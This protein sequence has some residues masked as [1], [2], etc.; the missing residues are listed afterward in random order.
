M[1]SGF[2][3]RLMV[4]LGLDD[5]ELDRGLNNQAK[6]AKRFGATFQTALG[7]AAGMAGAAAATAFGGGILNAGKSLLMANASAEQYRNSLETVTG[8]QKR[9]NEM[10]ANLQKFAKDTPFEFPELVQSAINLEAFGINTDKWLTTIGDTA[11]A[12][13]KSVDQVTQAIMDA[14]TGEYERLKELGIK[15]SVDGDK[16]VLAYRGR[17]VEVDKTNREMVLS[18]IQ[19][20]WNSGYAGAMKKQSRTFIGQWST[21]K[22]NINQLM[23]RASMGVFKFAKNGLAGVN[24]F[25]SAF[26]NAQE[27]GLGT[28]DALWQALRSTVLKVFGRETFAEVRGTLDSIR[29]NVERVG[30]V[31]RKVGAA[32]WGAFGGVFTFIGKHAKTIATLAAG[33]LSVWAAVSAGGLVLG[34]I[35]GL[36]AAFASPF[37]LLIGVAALFASAYI[38]NW[39]GVRDITNKVVKKVLPVIGRLIA[40]FMGGKGLHAAIADLP[41]PV[42]KVAIMFARLSGMV[43]NF[44]SA[45]QRNGPVAAF[46]QFSHDLEKLGRT[47]GNFVAMA[48]LGRSAA[49]IKDGFRLIG[50]II[51]QT[52]ALVDNLIHGRWRAAL[53]NLGNIARLALE[54]LIV[55]LSLLPALVLD[56]FEL[57]P[58]SKVG[59]GLWKGTKKAVSWFFSTAVPYIDRKGEGLFEALLLAMSGYWDSDIAPWFGG[60]LKAI[61]EKLGD[62]Y[63]AAWGWGASLVRGVWDSITGQWSNV[64]TWVRNNLSPSA[65]AVHLG[66][67][68]GAAFGWGQSLIVGL[69]NGFADK[70]GAFTEWLQGKWNEL[71]AWA[72]K[73]WGVFS[74]SKLFA[75]YGGYIVAGLRLGIGKAMPGLRRT[76]NTLT[77]AVAMDAGGRFGFDGGGS[78]SPAGAA[79]RTR[80]AG[81]AAAAAAGGNGIGVGGPVTVNVNGAGDP[82]A[83]ADRVVTR[84]TRATRRVQTGGGVVRYGG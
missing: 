56:V 14:S 18:T 58:W 79:V 24:H 46:R 19:T 1:A 47:I 48:G 17:Q 55:R 77:S 60:L 34:I 43:R 59:A 26:G 44:V 15:A 36:L 68:Y 31:A 21:L 63:S 25:F 9:A 7:T 62:W 82:D 75:K 3:S 23:Q 16:V 11:S 32:L 51:R 37:L 65:L 35:T 81:M 74:P 54:L 38:G 20:L 73:I 76:V 70:W 13:G 78:P 29:A 12:M 71:P 5:R 50:A 52:V 39:L 61:E 66:D 57:I 28:S 22:D 2:F 84:L 40:I 67:W 49:L 72:R 8:S 83:V 33:F 10:F 80:Y 45:W 41:A 4:H 6:K 42:Q 30:A 64:A 69:Q 27:R 53:G